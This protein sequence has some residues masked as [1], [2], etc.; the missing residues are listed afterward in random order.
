MTLVGRMRMGMWAL[1][2]LAAIM[3]SL[4]GSEMV[5]VK[6]TQSS[7]SERG[8]QAQ[9][10]NQMT[11]SI[12][13]MANEITALS[14]AAS[15]GYG[16]NE[17]QSGFATM[18]DAATS[19]LDT[20]SAF[21][22]AGSE[23]AVMLENV[24]NLLDQYRRAGEEAF[25]VATTAPTNLVFKISPARAVG[26]ELQAAA[27]AY[28]DYA[29][30]QQKVKLDRLGLMATVCVILTAALGGAIF[31]FGIGSAWLIPNRVK[32]SL[33]EA[34]SGIGSSASELLAVAS[35][36]AASTAQTAA[37]TNETTVT[38]EEVKQTAQLAHEKASEVAASVNN[39]ART[40]ESGRS[41]VEG[42]ISGIEQMQSEMAV[43][44]D[45]VR[46]LSEQTQAV[47]DIMTTVNDI[48]EQSNLLSVNASIEAAKAG[49][50][51]KGFTVVAQEVKSLAEQSKQAVAQV[52][53]ILSEIQKASSMAVQAA[54]KGREAV[55]AGRQQSQES[56]EAIQELAESAMEAAQSAAQISASSRQQLA[57]MEQIGQAI[58]SINEA[59]TQSA[60]GTRQVEREVKHLEELAL[61]LKR[62]VEADATN[63]EESNGSTGRS[64]GKV[65]MRA[66]EAAS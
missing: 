24:R 52:R 64:Q 21:E 12:F 46:G 51:G 32:R 1:V 44:S 19:A 10:A 56:G 25:S 14:D 66:G 53:T 13:T 20:A 11:T 39:V 3:I 6:A 30:A 33:N 43:I 37:S 16:F 8:L 50:H 2:V 59:G 54:E 60:A 62:L 35:Q 47:G 26:T 48:A 42:T 23:G 5:W 18:S 31:L 49:E 40:A 4:N 28:Q 15:R 65:E 57:G 55:E 29:M 41:I 61:K 7:L 38:V 36:V 63:S 9:A 27:I 22:K 58:A 17:A 45:T 34:A